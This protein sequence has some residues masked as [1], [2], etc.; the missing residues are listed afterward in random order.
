[1]LEFARHE[2]RLGKRGKDGKTL[3]ETLEVVARMKGGA[4]PQEGINPVEFPDELGHVWRWF[5][6]LNA[7]R[8]PSGMGGICAITYP[9]MLSY[10]SLRREHPTQWEMDLIKRLDG[11]A[12]ESCA[13]DEKHAH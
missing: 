7:S 12:L 1:M 10:F 11:I 9:D 13:K 2:F 4:I 6:D 3:R 8:Q 5:L